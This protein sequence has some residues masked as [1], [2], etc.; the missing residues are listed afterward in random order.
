MGR[1]ML[2]LASAAVLVF[3]YFPLAIVVIYAFNE[4]GTS[5]WP[6]TGFTLQWVIDAL[7]NTG[8]RQA[9]VTSVIVALGATLMALVLGSLLAIAVARYSFFGKE[10]I[11]FIVILPIALPGIV[12]GMAL[13][14]TFATFDVPLGFLTIVVGHATFCIVLVYNNAIARFRR[15]N[16]SLEEASA[17]LGADSFFTFRRVTFP[18]I[19]S[20]ML[21]G[22]LLA[23]ALSFDEVIVTIFTAGGVQTLPIWI[24]QAFRLANQVPLVFVAGLVAILLSVIPVYVAQRISSDAGAVAGTR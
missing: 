9:F 4:S 23:F 22:A 10:T 3:I 24:F 19:R 11:S 16:R 8:L 14:T 21:A 15:T 12:T 7:E 20:A 13:S 1:I 2:R 6:P 17:D 18:A 5:A